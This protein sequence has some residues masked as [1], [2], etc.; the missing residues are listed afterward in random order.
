MKRPLELALL[1]GGGLALFGLCFLAFLAVGG[2]PLAEVPVVGGLFAA[3]EPAAGEAGADAGA[4]PAAIGAASDSPL[5][6]RRSV[7]QE[8]LNASIGVLG[9]FAVPAPYSRDELEALVDELEGRNAELGERLDEVAARERTVSERLLMIEAQ[10]KELEQLREEIDVR[11]AELELRALE[12]RRDQ[13]S[14]SQDDTLRYANLASLYADGEVDQA[15]TDLQALGAAEAAK[16]LRRLDDDR[17]LALLRALPDQ[18]RRSF[19][20]AWATTRR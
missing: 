17:A 16:V 3:D 20:E 8:V 2:A 12:L 6:A 11:A 19:A 1:G 14:V 10:A 5:P 9:G 15:A 13:E 18:E 4:D 7:R